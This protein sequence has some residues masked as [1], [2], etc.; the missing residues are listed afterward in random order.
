MPAERRLGRLGG[1]RGSALLLLPA[2]FVAFLV[3]AAIAVDQSR[4]FAARRQLLDVAASAAND[5]VA[6]AIDEASYR[7]GHGAVL[8]TAQVEAEVR[9]SLAAHGLIDRVRPQ[10]TIRNGPGGPVVTVQ[11]ESDQ[12]T[13]FAGLAPGGYRTTPIRVTASA[14]FIV[15]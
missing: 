5:A 13:L 12:P 15:F 2:G 3:L 7:E 8:S 4:L 1:E 9:S 10:V 14:T 11:L 6:A